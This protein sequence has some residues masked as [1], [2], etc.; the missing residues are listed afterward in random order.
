M[1]SHR[2]VRCGELGIRSK[3]VCGHFVVQRGL[4]GFIFAD[5]C[6]VGRSIGA[7]TVDGVD[8]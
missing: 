6:M 7:D 3:F 1:V 4:E 8:S 5:E 2:R